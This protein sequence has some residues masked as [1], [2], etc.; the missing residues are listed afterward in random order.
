MLTSLVGRAAWVAS[1]LIDCA[2]VDPIQE[3]SDIFTGNSL[4]RDSVTPL[5]PLAKRSCILVSSTLGGL[6][7]AEI[8]LDGG[9]EG[10]RHRATLRLADY[11][12]AP[13]LQSASGWSSCECAVEYQT[14]ERNGL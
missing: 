8:P 2:I 1:L 13:S 6:S 9:L 12:P 7:R 10:G 3:L 5:P 11:A 14:A 4:D